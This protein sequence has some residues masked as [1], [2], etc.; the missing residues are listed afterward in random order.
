[1][2]C[3]SR[4]AGLNCCGGQ[5]GRLACTPEKPVMCKAMTCGA[6]SAESCCDYAASNCAAAG[7]PATTCPTKI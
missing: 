4:T 1:V 7:G 5:G 3:D 2:L 6:N